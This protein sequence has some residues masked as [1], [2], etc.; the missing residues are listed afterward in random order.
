MSNAEKEKEMAQA[1]DTA[2]ETSMDEACVEALA[3]DT[4]LTDEV[5]KLTQEKD[6]LFQRLLASEADMQNL[7]RRT[8]IDLANAHKFALEKFV[9]ELLPCIDA[10]EFE[11]NALEKQ[12]NLSEEL[13]KFKEGSELTYRMLLNAV[14]KFGVKQVR[15]M[16]EML[17]PE[18]HQAIT[19]IPN[20]GKPSNEI[21]DVV[22]TGYTLNDRLV[23]AAQVV[24]AQ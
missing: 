4:D 12:E 1:E 16:G 21:V 20:T 13:V 2:V 18:F 14:E 3:D 9:K 19:M 5:V 6:A 17:N 23:R 7:R 15:P 24:V 8:E 10:L 22:Q 11:I